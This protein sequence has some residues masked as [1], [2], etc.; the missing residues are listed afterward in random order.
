VQT[1]AA[2]EPE[3]GTVVELPEA[4]VEKSLV[5][6]VEPDY[7]EAALQQRIQGLVLL[8]VHIGT[9]GSVQVVR[10]AGGPPQLAQASS[11]AV[12]QWR[13]QPHTVKGR[14]VGVHTTV[15]LSFRLP[16]S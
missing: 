5:H 10:I 14:A 9:D 11:D 4:E 8:D 7:P 3:A 1:A 6:R 15:T 13:F 2:L 12:K 16:Q